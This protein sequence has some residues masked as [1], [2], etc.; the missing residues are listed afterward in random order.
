MRNRTCF[1]MFLGAVFA[2]CGSSDSGG[3]D[4]TPPVDVIEEGAAQELPALDNPAADTPAADVPALDLPAT[5]TTAIDAPP[6]GSADPAPTDTP[7]DANPDV[8]G[9]LAVDTP[10]DA[11]GL[12]NVWMDVLAAQGGSLVTAD[13]AAKVDIPAGALKADT[14][15][16]IQEMATTGLPGIADLGSKPF[17]I[18]PDG[19]QF[20]KTVTLTLSLN[21]AVPT[22][23]QAVLAWL[24]GDKWEPVAGSIGSGDAVTGGLS[25]FSIYVAR[26]VDAV[27]VPADYCAGVDFTA[28]GGDPTGQW[29]VVDLC[30]AAPLD[31]PALDNPFAS[32]PACTGEGVAFLATL[33]YN[34]SLK[35]AADKTFEANLGHA[36]YTLGKFADAC[37][38]AR[39]AQAPEGTPFMTDVEICASLSSP[40]AGVFGQG[41]TYATG[42]CTCANETNVTPPEPGAGTWAVDGTHLVVTVDSSAQPGVGFCV[43]GGLLWLENARDTTTGPAILDRLVF[44]K[45]PPSSL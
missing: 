19:T 4:L 1:V 21:G 33:E 30:L 20:D 35:L 38:E 42:W 11:P 28:C 10:A 23:K 31:A 34:G 12:P 45:A 15:V 13:G 44:K 40:L 25:H 6:D 5:D 8:A 36:Q 22:G 17:Q 2:A 7:T 26:F 41:C 43:A 3:T 37:L 18:G 24:D 29:D 14:K 16:T 32:T 39:L 27:V 9:E